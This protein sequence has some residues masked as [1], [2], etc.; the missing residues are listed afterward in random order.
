MAILR[1]IILCSFLSFYFFPS[2]RSYTLFNSGK[3][4]YTILVS[5]DASISEKYAADE[6]QYWL[7]EIS[8][9][10]FPI[11]N[12][13]HSINK[14]RIIVGYISDIMKSYL[15]QRPEDNDQGFIYGNHGSDIF[16]VGGKNIGTLYG[17]YSFLENELLCRWYSKDV[18][19]A[20]KRKSWTFKDLYDKETPAF[21]YRRVYYYDALDEDWSIRNK[22]NGVR[23]NK[24]TDYGYF[25]TSS[26]AIW[27]THTFDILLPSEKYFKSHPEYFSLR[28]GKR[29]K[30]QLCLSNPSVLKLCKDNL[31]EVIKKN[32]NY[33]VY[34][35]TQNDGAKPCQCNNCLLLVEKYGGE[36]GILIWF[37]NQIAESLESD[38]PDKLFGTF[39]YSFTRTPPINITP[40]KNVLVR[41]CASG[42]CD[43]HPL[44]FC[45][46][47][48][49]F[50]ND[51]SKWSKISFHL[52]I[53]DYVV[54]FR[55]Y[56]MPFAN[57][58]ALKRNLLTYKSFNVHGVLNLGIY[59][60]TGG[61]FAEL[62]TYLLVK[63]LWNPEANV[64][65]LIDDFMKGYYQNSSSFMKLYF[66]KV[67]SLNSDN[68]HF[69]MTET[70]RNRV[71]SSDFINSSLSL[72]AKAEE[73]ANNEE[74][75][76]RV[77]RQKMV[78]A[79][80]HCKKDPEHAIQDGSY[81]LVMYMAKKI[82]MKTFAE[83]GENKSIEDFENK[84]EKIK[85]SMNNKYSKEYLEY[86]LSKFLEN[87]KI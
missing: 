42:C 38:F 82:G 73:T 35:I 64:D 61:D 67:Q 14:K 51:L 29:N 43:L 45:E 75:L 12:E 68:V 25:P 31:R 5:K 2:A 59:N 9:A 17:V 57:F 40:R 52:Y 4:D 78:I 62:R 44:G 22:N 8:G 71:Y 69:I 24:K 66:E 74:V 37:V 23:Y 30:G 87:I 11:V 63:L 41:L 10:T 28:D 34:S 7:R 46:N 21:E 3:T 36:S 50:I 70:D 26:Y 16:I 18:T 65:A 55:Q 48:I 49:S 39:A 13:M 33:H 72:L 77:R 83:F 60:T 53:W 20:P 76:D 80:L 54:S 47:N 86:K 32:P 15:I 19:I 81:D 58:E 56:L 1:F 6:L 84:M 85:K 27:G 79:F